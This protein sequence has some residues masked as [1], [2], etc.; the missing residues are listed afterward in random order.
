M[1][2]SA[3]F[4]LMLLSYYSLKAQQVNGLAKDDQGK[5]LA[6]ASI[7][8]KK[9]KDSSVVKLSISTAT[10]HY[11]FSPIDPGSY[12]IFISHVGYASRS[13]A[14]FEISGNGK[15]EVANI[16]LLRAPKQLRQAVVQAARPLVEV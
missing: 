12:F 7:A 9:T 1:R 11:E 10:G 3:L 4:L 15:M 8:L 16:S 14:S 13:S 2:I 5:P 6:N